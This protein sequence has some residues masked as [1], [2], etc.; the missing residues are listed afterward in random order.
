[1]YEYAGCVTHSRLSSFVIPVA[2][3]SFPNAPPS[4]GTVLVSGTIHPSGFSNAGGQRDLVGPCWGAGLAA[5]DGCVRYPK[6]P[7]N[8]QMDLSSQI[9]ISSTEDKYKSSENFGLLSRTP[10]RKIRA[11][12]RIIG[13]HQKSNMSRFLEKFFRRTKLSTNKNL[14]LS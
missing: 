14:P 12:R 2:L 10:A 8:L 1:M 13:R 3:W 7:S 9:E 11:S 4:T 5:H 6:P